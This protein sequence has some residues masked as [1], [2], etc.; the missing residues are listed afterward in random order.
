ML[1]LITN[2]NYMKKYISFGVVVLIIICGAWFVTNSPSASTT[3]VITASK[4]KR[5]IKI[6]IMLPLTSQFGTIGEGVGKAANMA[7]QDYMKQHPN[8][9]I[10]TVQEDDKFDAKVGI[11]A[12]TKM[13]SLYKVDSIFIV[14]TPV[15][16]A[17]N[18]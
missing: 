3:K 8:V 14:S 12:Y 1:T 16:D 6:G 15:L 18:Q 10:T 17:V 11:A 2:I 7:I 13:T 4:E 9:T 5:V